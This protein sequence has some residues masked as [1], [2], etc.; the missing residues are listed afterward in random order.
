MSGIP[1]A[2]FSLV[3]ASARGRG[4]WRTARVQKRLHAGT[5]TAPTLGAARAAPS[6]LQTDLRDQDKAQRVV[7]GPR[8]ASRSAHPGGG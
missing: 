8:A 4:S 1:A 6:L 3:R 7:G 2:Q 5:A